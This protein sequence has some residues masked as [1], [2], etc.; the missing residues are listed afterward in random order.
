MKFLRDMINDKTGRSAEPTAEPLAPLRRPGED[1]KPHDSAQAPGDDIY[2]SLAEIQSRILRKNAER[3]EEE[4]IEDLDEGAQPADPAPAQM[5]NAAGAGLDLASPGTS[6]FTTVE[7]FADLVAGIRGPAQEAEATPAGQDRPAPVAAMPA[8]PAGEA[9]RAPTPEAVP[10]PMPEPM[11]EQ[12]Q[13]APA[14]EPAPEAAPESAPDA[15]PDAPPPAAAA[16]E[17]SGEAAGEQAQAV[18]APEAAPEPASDA[19]PPAEAAPAAVGAGFAHEDSDRREPGP[20]ASGKAPELVEHGDGDAQSAPQ[21]SDAQEP[22]A[23]APRAVARDPGEG[24]RPPARVTTAFSRPADTGASASVAPATPGAASPR[25]G[26]TKPITQPI[27]LERTAGSESPADVATG[28]AAGPASDPADPA[29]APLGAV[30]VPAPAAGRSGRRA[31]RVKTRLLGF[32]HSHGAALDPFENQARNTAA[33]QVAFPVGWLVVE[34]GPGRGTSFAL[35]AGASSIGRGDDQAICLD[36]GD[37]SIS[38]HNHAAIAYDSE[39]R[40]FYLGHGGKANLVRLNDRPV[41]STEEMNS[42]DRIRIGETTL[43]FIGLCGSEFDWADTGTDSDA[44]TGTGTGTG[45]DHAA[46]A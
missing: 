18:P 16:P 30:E 8:T 1:A 23:Q 13:A 21:K 34:H 46:D 31:G 29:P 11:P 10:E 36:F 7:E 5:H 35:R 9:P 28:S 12:A 19:P 27:G 37:N 2:K 32:E 26:A 6:E 38:R 39:L 14:P 17:A 15:A 42:G 45:T 3:H 20:N 43:R 22:D 4:F 44:D 41:L 25:V 24:H 33:P 40:R